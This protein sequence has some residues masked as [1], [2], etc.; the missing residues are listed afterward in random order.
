MHLQKRI[1]KERSRYLESLWDPRHR[2]GNSRSKQVSITI[3]NFICVALNWKS[4]SVIAVIYDPSPVF[5][6]DPIAPVLFKIAACILAIG[7]VKIGLPRGNGVS[8]GIWCD[9]SLEYEPSIVSSYSFR[10]GL[11][12]TR[13]LSLCQSICLTRTSNCIPK[14]TPRCLRYL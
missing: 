9:P 7:Y 13:I 14:F 12:Q 2:G 10:W 3:N 5:I 1:E 11:L 8:E 4:N 6:F